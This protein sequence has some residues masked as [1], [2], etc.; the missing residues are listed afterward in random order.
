[1]EKMHLKYPFT[2]NALY[3]MFA[4]NA[5]GHILIIMG[6]VCPGLCFMKPW[7]LLHEASFRSNYSNYSSYYYH[8]LYVNVVCVYVLYVS[9]CVW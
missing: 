5:T 9:V 2:V 7:P 8:L 1:M 3:F 6:C 4:L